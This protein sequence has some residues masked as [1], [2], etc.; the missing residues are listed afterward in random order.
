ME[1]ADAGGAHTSS[2]K[3]LCFSLCMQEHV[4]TCCRV[5]SST[6]VCKQA[7]S[8]QGRWAGMEVRLAMPLIRPLRQAMPP[9]HARP[10][11]GPDWVVC[12][13]VHAAL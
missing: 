11:W 8:R 13:T 5:E 9:L 12:Y 1:E 10:R 6:D 4:K 3:V 2:G 7:R